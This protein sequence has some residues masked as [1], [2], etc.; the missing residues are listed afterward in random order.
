ML[1]FIKLL[2]TEKEFQGVVEAV[3]KAVDEQERHAI[4][5]AIFLFIRAS[6]WRLILK[7][8]LPVGAFATITLTVLGSQATGQTPIGIVSNDQPSVVLPTPNAPAMG[9]TQDQCPKDKGWTYSPVFPP[10]GAAPAGS[11][12]S[13]STGYTCKRDTVELTFN[14]LG[15]VTGYSGSHLM[16]DDE[17]KKELLK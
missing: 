8:G 1:R 9:A 16:T 13:G 4:W 3:A 17:V 15:K 7:F 12:I 2:G 10:P 5:A 14:N 11:S 6:S